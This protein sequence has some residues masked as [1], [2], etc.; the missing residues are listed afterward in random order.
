MVLRRPITWGIAAVLVGMP[1]S[2][3]ILIPVFEGAKRMPRVSQCAANL[4]Q[5]GTGL[6]MY[7]QDYDEHFPPAVQS[8]HSGPVTIPAILHPYLRNSDVWECPAARQ[9]GARNQTFD[10][11]SNDTSISYGYNG[12]AL[13]P[14]GRGV[15][16]SQIRQPAATIAFLDSTSPLT[17]PTLLVPVL[18]GTAPAYRH[19]IGDE[20]LFVNVCWVDGHVKREQSGK[21]EQILSEEGG[22]QLKDGIDRFRYWNL[23]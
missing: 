12:H 13:A 23:R 18:G 1:L 4:K 11:T 9:Q 17:T 10:G 22:K 19:R 14:G 16:A 20:P 6:Q 21:L 7:V 5:L 15:R 2:C 3:A 8:G